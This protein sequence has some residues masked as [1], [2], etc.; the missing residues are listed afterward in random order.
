MGLVTVRRAC[1]FADS[2][3][4]RLLKPCPQSGRKAGQQGKNFKKF[5][6]RSE[7]GYTR[8]KKT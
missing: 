5:S 6:G 2:E 1:S 7:A 3:D 4:P 8:I